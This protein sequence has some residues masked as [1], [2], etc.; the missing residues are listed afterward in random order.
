MLGAPSSG[1]EEVGAVTGPHGGGKHRC[2][3]VPSAAATSGVPQ[4]S[5][6]W[7]SPAMLLS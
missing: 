2:P 7:V 5:F 1:K 6:L 3:C 4:A